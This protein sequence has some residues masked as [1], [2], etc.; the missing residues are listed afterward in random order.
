M[1]QL[2]LFVSFEYLCYRSTSAKNIVILFS[3]GTVFRSLNVIWYCLSDWA[4]TAY[5]NNFFNMFKGRSHTTVVRWPSAVHFINMASV[6]WHPHPLSQ[7]YFWS[8]CS[9][10]SKMTSFRIDFQSA[11][12]P[13][14]SNS[15]LCRIARV[16]KQVW[17]CVNAH[18]LAGTIRRPHG[19]PM[20][21]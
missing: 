4:F 14:P 19:G 8:S 9:V 20:L 18:Y 6:F 17:N 12:L 7:P 5:S 16:Q 21:G 15:V 1:S 13:L 2:A 3:A 11:L 10:Y